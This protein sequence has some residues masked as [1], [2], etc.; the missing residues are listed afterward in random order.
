MSRAHI[1]LHLKVAS[2]YIQFS[3]V[4][5]KLICRCCDEP[6]RAPC[7]WKHRSPPWSWG[8]SPCTCSTPAGWCTASCTPNLATAPRVTNALRPSWQGTP[9]YRYLHSF[10]GCF[11]L[12]ERN[13]KHCMWNNLWYLCPWL[14]S[15][16]FTLLSGP[17]QRE[18]TPWS[19][20]KSNLMWTESLR[21]L[22]YYN[23]TQITIAQVETSFN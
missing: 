3:A 13:N 17:T 12:G 15:W 22:V 8:C 5:F 23:I 6:K 10:T 21:G 14:S 20:K 16:V 7:S 18:D 4:R 2:V 11:I 9:N 19:T 1:W